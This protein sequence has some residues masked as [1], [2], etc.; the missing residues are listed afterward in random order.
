MAAEKSSVNTTKMPTASKVELRS[1][2]DVSSYMATTGR[3]SRMK[4]T[5]V[6]MRPT[7]LSIRDC[8]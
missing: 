6:M 2:T 4:I 1:P 8:E 3:T 5:S 7:N